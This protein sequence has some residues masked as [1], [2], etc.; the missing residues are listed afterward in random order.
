MVES[1]V[2]PSRQCARFKVTRLAKGPWLVVDGAHLDRLV[3][4]CPMQTD[5][6]AVAALMEGDSASAVLKVAETLKAL[7]VLNR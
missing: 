4:S 7:D 3:A 2:E 5:A 1:G 6:D